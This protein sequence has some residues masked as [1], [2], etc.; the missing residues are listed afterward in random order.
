MASLH[1]FIHRRLPGVLIL[2]LFVFVAGVAH[3]AETTVRA[4]LNRGVSVIG[5]PV[6][7]Q[8]KISG[9]RHLGD[10]PE[11]TV[12]GL[13]IRFVG[14]NNEAVVHMENGSFISELTTTYSYHV[15]PQ[16]NGSFTI[17]PV[18][19]EA[20]GKKY[21]T[22]PVTLTVQPSS[23]TDGDEGGEKIAFAEFVIGK[24]TAYLGEAIPLE[25]RLYVDARVRS[26]VDS[27][28]EIDGE[29]FTQQRLT[30]P[31]KEEVE[32]NGHDYIL[33]SFRTLITPIRAGKLTVGPS[34]ISLRARVPRAQRSRGRSP[35]DIFGDIF[36]DDVYSATQ[37]L[38]AKAEG[39]ELTV[40]PLPQEGK[41]ADFAGAVG[42]FQFSAEGSP[43]Q[44]KIGDPITM[45]L[46]ISGKGN[47]DRVT[48]PVLIE[49]DGWRTYPPSTTFNADDPV[50]YTG[51]K[52][53][54]EAVIPETKKTA[55]PS[56]QFSYFD[57]TA[58]KYVTVKSEA[59]PLVVQGEMPPAPAASPGA[60]TEEP[61]KPVAEPRPQDIV[62]LRY[63]RDEP[64][65]F[66][67]LY[68]RREFWLAQGA[69]GLVLLGLV[70]F[71]IRR[72][73]DAAVR[74]KA[75]L[76]QEKA[77]VWRRLRSG[78][79]GHV[80]FFDAAARLAQIETAL[81]T[82]RPVAAVDAAAVRQSGQ[83]DA[84]AAETI[85]AV[86]SARAEVHYAGG[87]GGERQVSDLD[88]ERVIG[89]LRQLE[90]GHAKS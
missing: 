63:E 79:L 18:T 3:A 5:D 6:E 53:F 47:F 10:P 11:I 24:K 13:E 67:P 60:P 8:I 42:N 43:K 41:P 74:Q 51:A 30:E 50:N 14:N 56:Y 70:G 1:S 82:G 71:K 19:V 52:T 57:P 84:A 20:E 35:F 88:R 17:P 7:L 32:R 62:G 76:R 80:D 66:A 25:L 9:G 49:P 22:Q 87:G 78:D 44:V 59:S 81:A 65:S 4:H 27:M 54:E 61:P 75:S 72:R 68:E 15:V 85:D 23:A 90:A 69:A 28:P 39:V 16:R 77:A 89:A 64:H 48:A 38:K 12:D 86:F 33:L 31:R 45:K 34:E 36:G 83:L 26:Q 46:K 2:V 29:G 40:K 73:P 55:M 21:H 37:Q 58:E